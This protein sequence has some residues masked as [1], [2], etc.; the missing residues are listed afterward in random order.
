MSE[1]VVT[2]RELIANDLARR[3]G[4]SL[5]DYPFGSRVSLVKTELDTLRKVQDP[6]LRQRA[7]DLYWLLKAERVEHSYK[8]AADEQEELERRFP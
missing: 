5:D 6:E 1:R 8:F 3:S 7:W 4:V 2:R